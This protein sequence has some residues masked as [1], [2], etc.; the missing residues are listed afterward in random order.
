MNFIKISIGILLIL[1]ASRFIP[2]PPNFTT[3]IALSFYAPAIFG[4]RFIP[5]VALSFV[6]TDLYFGFHGTTLFTWGSVILIGLYS[7]YLSATP[8]KRLSGSF[9][10]ACLFFILTNF[11][12][13]L[14]GGYGYT[15]NG[16]VA[17]YTMAI[18]FFVSTI[19]ST[20]AFSLLIEGIIKTQQ[21]FISKNKIGQL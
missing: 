15:L 19:F 12:V 6:I 4:N 7:K 3:L 17:S 21:L 5:A 18:P 13:W 20:F 9:L 14:L 2:H 16:L 8:I 11:G 10:G 1:S